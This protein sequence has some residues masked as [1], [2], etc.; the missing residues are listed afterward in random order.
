MSLPN[1]LVVPHLW[2]SGTRG[3]P[4]GPLSGLPSPC[5]ALARSSGMCRTATFLRRTANSLASHRRRARQADARLDY[6]LEDLRALVADALD[7]P[8]PYCGDT[9]RD[10]TFSCDHAD[11][12]SRGGSFRLDNLRICCRRCNEAKGALTD[13]EFCELLA[14][15]RGWPAQARQD[16]LRR[17]RAGAVR[18]R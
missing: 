13:E 8:C 12:T 7:H 11:A 2:P 10:G 14:V 15:V 18:R 1:P 5:S 17:L 4:A 16:V 6:G 3:H 9:L